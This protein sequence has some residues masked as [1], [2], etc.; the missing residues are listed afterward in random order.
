MLKGLMESRMMAMDI[1][2]ILHTRD[3]LELDHVIQAA[4]VDPGVTEK[5]LEGLTCPEDYYRYNCFQSLLKITEEHPY[6]VYP[7]WQRL[8]SMLRSPNSFQRNIAVHLLANLTQADPLGRFEQIA[9]EYLA[10]L[11]DESIIPARSLAQNAGRIARFKPAL[12][13]RITDLLLGVEATHHKQKELLKSDVIDAFDEYF[14]ETRD[15]ERILEFIA[16]QKDSDSPRT[17]KAARAFL[18]KWGQ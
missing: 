11:D 7:A 8:A 18:E 9:D 15:K 17:R 3:T 4:I 5:L 10:L 14:A 13:S 2:K 6:L 1:D 16:Q 12:Q